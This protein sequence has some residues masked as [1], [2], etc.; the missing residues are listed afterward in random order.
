M[1]TAESKTSVLKK[2]DESLLP[3][4][5]EFIPFFLIFLYFLFS[6]GELLHVV[7]YIF[8]PKISHF[9][10]VLL[11]GYL[12]FTF[13]RITLPRSILYPSLWLLFSMLISAL[14]SAHPLRSCIYTGVY[15][16]NFVFYF[17]IPVNLFQLFDSKTIIKVYS[18]AFVCLGLYAFSQLVFSLFG[19]YDPLATQRVGP[20]ARGQG[21]TYEPSYYALYMTAF[22]MFRNALAIFGP[23]TG[24]SLKRA[25]KLLGVNCFLLVSTSTGVIFTYP[26]FCLVSLGM[27]LVR[28]IR[29]VASNAR[30]RI[31]KFIAICCVLGS[32]LSCLFWEYFVLSFFK[33]FYF[34]FESHGSFT[35]RW[36][37]IVSCLKTFFEHPMLGVG[38]GGIGPYLFTKNSFYDTN[39]VSLQEVELYDPTN[40]FTEILASLGIVGFIGFAVLSYVFY[41]SFK[42]VIVSSQISQLDKIIAASLFI[43]LITILFVLQFNQGLFRPY[44][45]IHAGVVYGYLQRLNN[46]IRREI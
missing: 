42:K 27:T 26:V 28:P 31:F 16:F 18:L 25:F 2:E 7:V 45:W 20:I 44:L 13:R 40:V 23:K 33:F 46:S 34:G 29:R 5:G 24:F 21:W 4:V 17:L 36:E 37:G 30:K 15:F 12:C 22:V 10:G 3:R 41:R 11:F 19:I 1:F 35:A 43:S 14:L 6:S 8:K 9:L 38:A 32:V 39:P